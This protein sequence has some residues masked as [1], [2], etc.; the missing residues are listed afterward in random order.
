MSAHFIL[1][2]NQSRLCEK[3]LW[4]S[5]PLI[6]VQSVQ[7]GAYGKMGQPA[8]SHFSTLRAGKFVAGQFPTTLRLL[9]RNYFR[10]A[11]SGVELVG[12]R[13]CAPRWIHFVPVVT[14]RF[15]S[16]NQFSTTLICIGAACAYSLGLSIRR[17]WPSGETS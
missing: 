11:R 8:M 12:R 17:R 2:N 15:N 9:A 6:S 16:S 7:L 4:F 1:L 5:K 10:L 14:R 13:F 3:F